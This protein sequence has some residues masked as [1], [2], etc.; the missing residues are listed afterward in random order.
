MPELDIHEIDKR[1]H[2]IEEWREHEGDARS[3]VRS[4]IFK[5]LM[6]HDKAI[7]GDDEN[8]GLVT[9]VKLLAA[10]QAQ[11][12]RLAYLI[13]FGC[14]SAVGAAVWSAVGG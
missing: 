2:S 12:T 13:V 10:N 5:Q 7:Y 4:D 8:G 6:R 3:S 14:M 9:T 1:L 11:L